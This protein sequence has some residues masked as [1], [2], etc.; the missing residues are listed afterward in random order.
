MHD[1]VY[2]L[3]IGSYAGDV[4]GMTKV[5]E[6]G[7]G[8]YATKIQQAAFTV[9]PVHRSATVKLADGTEQENGWLETVWHI[10]GLRAEQYT[11]LRTYKIAHTT[12]VYIRTLDEDG[13]GYKNY[14]AY[15]IWPLR[16]N[17]GD[18]TAVE[19]GVVFDFELRFTALEEVGID[20]P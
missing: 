5:S 7:Q 4:V 3:M 18:P 20:Y 2:E 12:Q 14:L 6:L 17:R 9:D 15:M 8:V 16:P 1:D 11:A 13:D 10:N 19:G